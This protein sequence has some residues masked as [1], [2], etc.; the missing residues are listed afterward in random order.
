M[1]TQLEKL[2]DSQVKLTVEIDSDQV[3]WA[4]AKAYQDMKKDFNVQG[5]RKGKVPRAMIEK[6]YGV[7]VFFNKAAD[8]LIEQT[9]GKAIEDNNVDIAARI[10]QEGIQVIE[11]SKD[12]MKY[13]A[14][15]TVKPEFTLGD[16]KNL[17][18]EVDKIEVT[19]DDIDAEIAKEA[20]K[21]S[22]EISITDR[23][24]EDKDTVI[25]DFKGFIDGEPFE[26]GSAQDYSLVIGSKSFIE[27]F[28]EQ[29]I[30][31]QSGDN[32]E[33]NVTFPEN[34]HLASLAGKPAVFEVEIKDIKVKEVPEINDDFAADV[35]EFETLSEY[36]QSIKDRLLKQKE[37][38]QQTTIENKL[39]EL[40]VKNANVIVP[41]AMTE[42][43][44]DKNVKNFETR[45]SQ[46]GLKL[47]HYI[48][49]T[50]QNMETFR[51]NIREDAE[52]QLASRLV[53]DKIALQEN[54][55]ITEEELDSE[56]Q[57]IAK[58]YNMEFEEL[59]KIFP[60]YEKESLESDL[61]VKKAVKLIV[62]SAKV[63]EK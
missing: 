11:M 43:Q 48:Q 52:K 22:R 23:P 56:L 55:E 26:G 8:I 19:D 59:K 50:G 1:N 45:L 34:Y 30:G 60:P 21:N 5:F 29:L 53:L 31:K 3:T 42:D 33:I 25:I 16:Y 57:E 38:Q 63:I 12:S 6:M 10:G 58:Y 13:E 15:I 36:K 44:I 37:N 18:V 17:E 9:I 41:E 62:D 27:G 28:E 20:D 24:I 51:E 54:I 39:I 32:A 61:K 4:I 14:T 40:A 46:Q 35:S 7:E 49:F 2:E 47:E